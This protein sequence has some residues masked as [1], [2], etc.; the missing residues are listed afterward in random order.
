MGHLESP[1]FVVEIRIMAIESSSFEPVS[2]IS[3]M[4]VL[5][6]QS[7]FSSDN[8][9]IGVKD[10]SES[11]VQSRVCWIRITDARNIVCA[12]RITSEPQTAVLDR[13]VPHC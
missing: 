10:N 9:M 8:R 12:A 7:T 2:S 4:I 3:V 5:K 13:R 1:M 11:V 6:S